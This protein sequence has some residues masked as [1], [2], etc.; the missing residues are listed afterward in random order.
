MMQMK[1]K[2][3]EMQKVKDMTTEDQDKIKRL[4]K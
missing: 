3:Q 4:T 2:D 1:R